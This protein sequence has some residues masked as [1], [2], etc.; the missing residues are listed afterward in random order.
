MPKQLDDLKPGKQRGEF[1]SRRR[2]K[3]GGRSRHGKP[4]SARGV[5]TDLDRQ[6][7]ILSKSLPQQAFRAQPGKSQPQVG[8]RFGSVMIESLVK[9]YVR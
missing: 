8:Q 1:L 9:D 6:G 7:V 5:L 4:A 2:L 3:R